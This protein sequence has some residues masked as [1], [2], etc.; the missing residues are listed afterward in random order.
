MRGLDWCKIL[1]SMMRGTWHYQRP[2]ALKVGVL[3]L[4]GAEG[5]GPVAEHQSLGAW[6]WDTGLLVPPGAVL[7]S[8]R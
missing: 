6:G 3:Q 4:V 5:A 2:A 7:E 8:N 1:V